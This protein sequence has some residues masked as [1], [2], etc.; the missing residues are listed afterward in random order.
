M[1]VSLIG[2]GNQSTWKEPSTDHQNITDILLKVA[3][4]TMTQTLIICSLPQCDLPE[5][6]MPTRFFFIQKQMFHM[7]SGYFQVP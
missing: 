3:L 1:A 4:N 2:G 6:K 7:I 5:K